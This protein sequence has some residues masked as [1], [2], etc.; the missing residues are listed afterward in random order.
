MSYSTSCHPSEEVLTGCAL[1][2]ADTDVLHHLD[3]C[4]ECSEFVEDVRTIKNEIAALGDE[5][6]PMYLHE[7]I[8]AIVHQKK[9]SM[10]ITFI[11]NWYKNPFFY[12]I[13]TALFS[14]IVYAI[15]TFFL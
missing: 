1:E 2:K 13:L 14:I 4:A 3:Q 9:H 5:Q 6:I 12:G 10:I 8:M 15:F 11:Q 7:K